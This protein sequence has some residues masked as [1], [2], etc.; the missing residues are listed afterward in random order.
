MNNKLYHD[1]AS[2][3]SEAIKQNIYNALFE[4]PSLQAML[5][6]IK[7][8]TVLDLGCASGEH[9]K[10]LASKG[11][12]VTAVDI[13]QAMIDLIQK[14]NQSSL[15]AYAQDISKGLPNE[16][17]KSF[18]VVISGLTIHYIKD[19][20]PLFSDISRVLK[21]NGQFIFS[22]HHPVIDF[23]SSVSGNYFEKELITEEWDVIGKPVEV[24]FYRRPL[25]ELFS[26]ITQ[27][28]LCVT[29]LNEGMPQKEIQKLNPATYKRLTTKPNF[30]FIEC[31]KK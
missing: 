10:H 3:Y 16:Q 15:K 26:A 28:G 6:D 7:G 18:D 4:R 20:N 19:L 29:A 13:S 12:Y 24:S 5:P 31:T 30:L 9:S 27:A 22:T 23:K 14:Q 21:Q 1:Y 11:A 2:E 25:T 8:K 17:D